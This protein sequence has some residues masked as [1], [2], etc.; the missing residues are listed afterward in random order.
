M[1]KNSRHNTY[2]K[3]SS[4]HLIP[5]TGKI[6]QIQLAY[7]LLKEIVIGILI[8]SKNTKA[9]VFSLNDYIDF[10]IVISRELEGDALAQ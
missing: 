8:L 6:K 5:Y 4:R 1:C 2:L 9:M 10:F 7:G 3:I